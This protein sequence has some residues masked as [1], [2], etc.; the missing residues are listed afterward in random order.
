MSL[1]K[2]SNK[3]RETDAT[4]REKAAN[5]RSGLGARAALVPTRT[6][7]LASIIMGKQQHKNKRGV[8]RCKGKIWKEKI[9]GHGQLGKC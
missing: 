2:W 3:K 1:G 5:L 9:L 8:Q 6:S 4:E 7:K